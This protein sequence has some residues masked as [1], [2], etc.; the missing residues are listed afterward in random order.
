[1]KKR[2]IILFLMVFCF[3]AKTQNF[4]TIP[5]A[6]FANWLNQNYATCMNGNQMDIEC[7]AIQSAFSVNVQQ[8]GISDLTGIEYFSGLQI[9]NCSFNQLSFLPTLPPNLLNINC[10]ANNLSSLPPLPNSL[11]TIQANGNPLLTSFDAWPPELA[12][13]SIGGTSAPILLANIPPLPPSLTFLSIQNAQLSELPP[14]P[15]NLQTLSCANNPLGTL[16]PLP[17]SLISLACLNNNLNN[18]PDPLPPGLR[19][20][21]CDDNNLTQL[22]ALPNTLQQLMCGNNNLGALPFLPDSIHTI[23]ANNSNISSIPNIP[24]MLTY[25]ELNNN[26]LTSLPPL[27]NVINNLHC[28]N[29]QLTSLPHLP[30]SML[31]LIVTNNQISCWHPFPSNL[32]SPGIGNNP[33]TC[34]PNYIPSMGAMGLLSYPLCEDA[35]LVNNPF[36]CSSAKGISGKVYNDL[37]SDCLQS[38]GE[39]GLL[40]VPIRLFDAQ[41]NLV[42]ST[43]STIDGVYFLSA[44]TNT[45]TASVDTSDKPYRVVCNNPGAD[46]TLQFNPSFT[47]A[48]N[49][50]FAL[51][52]KPG[53]DIGVQSIAPFGWVFPG[54]IH[55]LRI[56]AGDISQWY[57][58]NCAVG[59]GGTIS[60]TISGPVSYQGV[61]QGAL[62][63]VLSGQIT[64]NYNIS[65]FASLNFNNDLRLLFST[66]TTAQADDVICVN[67]QVNPSAGDLDI[68]NNNF[69]Y[70]YQVVNSYDPNIK[71]VWPQR[72]EPPYNDYFN[73]T[74]Y[75]QNIGNAP[76]FNIRIADTLDGLLNTSTFELVNYS[77][78]CQAFL[79]GNLLSF[80][81]NNIMLPD[82]T[83]DPDGSIGFVQ[84]RIKPIEGLW[85]GTLIYNT[86]HIYFDF[87][88]AIVTNTTINE[89]MEMTGIVAVQSNFDWQIY[90]NPTTD[91]LQIKLNIDDVNASS[92]DIFS[93]SGSLV[94]SGIM[95]NTDQVINLSMLES[96]MYIIRLQNQKGISQKRFVKAS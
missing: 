44:D 16:P 3:K 36:G 4:V 33:F 74:I 96:G 2:Y 25:L 32:A 77:H 56:A 1:M 12:S 69:S 43:F 85:S 80:R 89:I 87:N 31:V 17:A 51:A 82:S 46:S 24:A 23:V 21:T 13:L 66:D 90:P 14:L 64:F 38:A 47:L 70:C 81:F 11:R 72:V 28:A 35:D 42:S 76:A 15:P 58:L 88:E 79:H 78:D 54:Q 91:V 34:L 83:S 55:T 5:D 86:A 10:I 52:C 57:G 8:Y 18:L 71:T 30:Q 49:V 9:L 68:S 63:P 50:D 93:I 19:F 29:N 48:Q 84:Y 94:Y 26:L 75:F 92:I 65:D 6:N 53:F 37:D 45:Y 7:P 61:P 59:V 95:H 41:S 73:Y 27:N 40:N 62:T 67:V 39:P 20:L 22:P 60:V